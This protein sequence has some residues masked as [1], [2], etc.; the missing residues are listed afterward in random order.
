MSEYSYRGRVLEHVGG[1]LAGVGALGVDALH[2]GGADVVLA[3]VNVPAVMCSLLLLIS[4]F[5]NKQL[6]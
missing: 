5:G 4:S 6:Y 2:A 3:L 1:A